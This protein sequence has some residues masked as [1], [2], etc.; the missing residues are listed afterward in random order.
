VGRKTQQQFDGLG[1]L[2]AVTEQDPSSGLLS[3]TTNYSYDL[4][5]NLTQVNQGGQ[6]RSWKYDAMGRKL[7]ENIPE[8][9]ATINDGTGTMWTCKWV[10]NDFSKVTSKTDARGV[11]ISYGYRHV[12]RLMADTKRRWRAV[13][14]AGPLNLLR[15]RK[16]DCALR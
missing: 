3:Q 8:Q 15:G 2:I 11:V 14:E 6:I 4:L 7:Y 16:W 1:R 5:D 10:Y 12:G 9:T 13:A